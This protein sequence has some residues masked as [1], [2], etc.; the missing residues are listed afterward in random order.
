[1]AFLGERVTIPLPGRV[2]GAPVVVA[3]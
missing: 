3:E 1:M 2:V